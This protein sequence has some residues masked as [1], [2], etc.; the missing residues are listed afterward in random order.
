MS[1]MSQ[2]FEVNSDL[3]KPWLLNY[4]LSISEH[5]HELFMIQDYVTCSPVLLPNYQ[6]DVTVLWEL[7]YHRR[8]VE[9]GKGNC[10]VLRRKLALTLIS[11]STSG[12]FDCYYVDH[13]EP[14][15]M[16]KHS[17][18]FS[19]LRSLPWIVP[20]WNSLLLALFIHEVGISSD[21]MVPERPL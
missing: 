20:V 3:A 16:L 6:V 17:M 2:E 1:E 5:G 13:T 8:D 21:S 10:S 4:I 14:I 9:E 15:L 11:A 19:V 7:R 18:V 12:W